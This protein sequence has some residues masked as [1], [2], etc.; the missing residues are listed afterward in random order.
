MTRQA[1]AEILRERAVAIV[2][3]HGETSAISGVPVKIAKWNGLRIMLSLGG[4]LLDMW[5]GAKVFSVRR[6]ES[7]TLEIVNFKRGP[8][9][10]A[11]SEGSPA[12]D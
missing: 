6:H 3:D 5:H 12:S 4:E 2:A 1:D 10:A 8:W 7:G 11:L 9:E